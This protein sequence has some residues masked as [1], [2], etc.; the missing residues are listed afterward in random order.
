MNNLLERYGALSV[1]LFSAILFIPFLGDVHLFDWDEINFAES[2]REMLVTGDYFRVHINYQP[3]WEKPPLFFWLQAGSM[4]LFGINEFSARFPNAI[5]GIITLA[6][7]YHIGKKHFSHEFGVWWVL[8]MAGSFTPFLYFKSG[9]IDPWFNLFI[10]ATLYQLYLASV[11]EDQE[12][13]SKRF[14][15]AG[16]LCGLAILT[17]GPVAFLIVLLSVL[18]KIIQNGFKTFF[19][20][21]LFLLAIIPLS[22]VSSLWVMAE[23]GKN[24]FSI[25]YD[26]ILYQIDL[27]RNPVAGHGQPFWYHPVVLLIGCFPASIFAFRGFANTEEN[28]MAQK[29][30]K[31][32][33]GILFWVVLI[34]FSIV[35]TK[36]VH[37]SSLCYLPLTF[38]AARG[39]YVQIKSL[40]RFHTGITLSVL[41]TGI[42][43]AILL[44]A[45]TLVHYFRDTITP[46]I[47]DDFAVACLQI[48]SPWD[49][50]E[51]LPGLL[52]LFIIITSVI[53]LFQNRGATPLIMLLSFN[54]V[55][56][57]FYLKLVVPKIEA[58]SQEP[59]ISFYQKIGGQDVYVESLGHKSYAQYF[60][61]RSK[62]HRNMN[63]TD[64]NWLLTGAIDKPAYFVVKVNHADKYLN[65]YPQLKE[66]GRKGGFVLLERM[67]VINT[68]GI[69]P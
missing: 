11:S 5:C 20:F 18:V 27:F 47:K 19:S 51:F 69:H 55:F 64:M 68:N 61:S 15:L 17:K 28:N 35:K 40:R 4:K 39:A 22:L 58:Y 23:V 31:L 9:I 52:F 32:W 41:L 3:F 37:Y 24:G 29:Q 26:F 1:A 36:I 30:L 59:A 53:L 66:T 50:Y 2:A 12:Y 67:P 45:V 62:P 43:L 44:I 56:I 25:I 6:S 8:F 49:G 21:R 48:E 7:I 33:M 14:L 16:V 65:M 10:F 60:Y 54:A 38:I 34:L 42:L 57:T 46:F 13:K 63:Y